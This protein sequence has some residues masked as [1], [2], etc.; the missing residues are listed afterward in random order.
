MLEQKITLIV[1]AF[2]ILSFDFFFRYVVIEVLFLKF[3]N[4]AKPSQIAWN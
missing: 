1:I 3:K 4:E 2:V